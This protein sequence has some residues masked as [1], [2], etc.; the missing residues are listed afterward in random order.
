MSFYDELKQPN[1]DLK[2]LASLFRQYISPL[3]Y[4]I[5]TELF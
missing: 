2:I 1:E 3:I 5:L 4:K